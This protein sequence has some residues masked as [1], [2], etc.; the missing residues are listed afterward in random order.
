MQ[1]GLP[2]KSLKNLFLHI[3][4]FLKQDCSANKHKAQDGKLVLLCNRLPGAD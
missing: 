2:A 3:F 1:I 4:C